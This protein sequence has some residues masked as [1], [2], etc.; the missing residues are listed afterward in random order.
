[1]ADIYKY[2]KNVWILEDPV[3]YRRE[4]QRY[5]DLILTTYSGRLLLRYINQSARVLLIMPY[6]PSQERKPINA[7][8]WPE[9]EYDGYA[10]DAPVMTPIMVPGYGK[11]MLPE[12]H[13]G[14]GAGT[15]S[16]LKYH[17]AMFRQ[18]ALNR[19]YYAPGFGPGEALFHEMVHAMRMMAGRF[20]RTTVTEDAHMDDFEEFCAI[21]AANMYRSERG[22]H[23]LRASHS[24]GDQALSEDLTDPVRYAQF[25]QTE[26][27]KWFESQRTFCLEL[28]QSPA[29][30]NP[31]KYVAEDLGVPPVTPM[32][33]AK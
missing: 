8:T 24:T 21:L 32:A 7:Y 22:F 25:F 3:A 1:M 12:G 16:I 17:P 14:T 10:R 9:S 6:V 20:L 27:E 23:V 4:V 13:F 26:I 11:I 29:S 5:L 15:S 2:K 28:A 30:F 18:L 33:V 19:G 31:M